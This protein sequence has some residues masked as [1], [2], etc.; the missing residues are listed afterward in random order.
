M[1]ESAY[2]R[3]VREFGQQPGTLADRLGHQSVHKFRAD[4]TVAADYADHRDGGHFWSGCPVC[5]DLD[6]GG[7]GLGGAR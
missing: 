3:A 6:A 4:G 1:S 2:D 5:R 7:D